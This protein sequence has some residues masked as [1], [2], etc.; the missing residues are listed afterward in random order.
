MKSGQNPMF[1][2]LKHFNAMYTSSILMLLTWPVVIILC[3]FAVR[4]TLYYYE[5][6][7]DQKPGNS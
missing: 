1:I 3:W 5:K 6:K 2:N 4:L 7:K